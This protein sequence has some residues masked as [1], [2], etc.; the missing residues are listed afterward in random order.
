[1]KNKIILAMTSIMALAAEP[2]L[3]A[4][5]LSDS[6]YSE[7]RTGAFAGMAVKMN[8]GTKEK[9]RPTARLQLG[10]TQNYREQGSGM[11]LRTTFQGSPLELGLLKGKPMLFV[12]VQSTAAIKQRAQLTGGNSWLYIAGGLAIAARFSPPR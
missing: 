6:G 12:G 5:A 9:T 7:R 2:A 10:M 3:A 1:M 8:L 4:N 11:P